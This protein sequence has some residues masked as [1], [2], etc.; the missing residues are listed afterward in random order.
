MMSTRA[1][2]PSFVVLA[3]ALALVMSSA[4]GGEATTAPADAAIGAPDAGAPSPDAAVIA[5]DASTPPGDD[6]GTSDDAGPCTPGA[7]GCCEDGL[8]DEDGDG[9]CS[10]ACDAFWCGP[11]GTC[12][13]RGNQ[14]ACECNA[15]YA[16]DTCADCALGGWI[17]R[18]ATFRTWLAAEGAPPARDALR[19]PET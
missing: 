13:V 9:I 15:G 1:P 11:E 10:P 16:G 4:C 18:H 17:F 3:A 12:T 14:R 2:H 8:Q 5:T 19:D 7:P 6:G